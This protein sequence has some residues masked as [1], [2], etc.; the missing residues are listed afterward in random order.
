MNLEETL[1]QCRQYAEDGYQLA[2]RYHNEIVNALVDEAQKFERAEHAQNRMYRIKNAELIE[3]QKQSLK[4][5]AAYVKKIRDDIEILH[6]RQKDF[7]VVVYGRTM[8]G[9]STLMEILTHGNGD[10]I[11]R[12]KIARHEL[13]NQFNSRGLA[14]GVCLGWRYQQA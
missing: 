6:E 7:T 2:I 8:A 10:S 3:R 5:L 12:G 9:K 11:G 1:Q 13:R 14:A 4:Q